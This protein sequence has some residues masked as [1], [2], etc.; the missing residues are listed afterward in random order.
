MEPTIEQTAG[1][2]FFIQKIFTKDLSFESPNTPA[3]FT[4]PWKPETNVA[5]NTASQKLDD[6]NFEVTLSVTATT[7]SNADVAY[8]AEVKQ[9]GVFG[10]TGAPESQLGHILGSF[11]P[12]TLFPYAREAISSLVTRGGFPELNLT[13]I[14]F[15]ALYAQSLQQ[16]Q[17]EVK[18]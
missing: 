18:H 4:K 2:E 16:A 13:P 6:K 7:K 9:T 5:I 10:I 8:V 14:N 17:N 11:C 12:N 1:V 3:I 15:D